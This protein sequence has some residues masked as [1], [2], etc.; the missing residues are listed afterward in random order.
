MA[1]QVR[2]EIGCSEDM[3]GRGMGMEEGKGNMRKGIWG[4]GMGEET[5][6]KG[7]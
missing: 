1:C 7:I 4:V 3:N 6:E 2:F 5:W